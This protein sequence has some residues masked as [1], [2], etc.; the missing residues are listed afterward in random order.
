MQHRAELRNWLIAL[1]ATAILVALCVAFVDR[2]AAI[3]FDRVLRHTP[4]L[5]WI[6]RALAPLDLTIAITL[7][8]LIASGIWTGPGRS[9]PAWMRVPWLVSW[10]AVWATLATIVL[11][12]VFGRASPDPVYVQAGLYG[13]RPL[14]NI[15]YWHSFPSGTAAISTAIA[16]ALWILLPR[17]R[18]PGVLLAALLSVAVVVVNYHWV[19]D[20][21]TGIFLGAFIG[22]IT[23][24]YASRFDGQ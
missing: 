15:P 14:H 5:A 18:S 21:I 16:T 1:A 3:F 17:W 20:V 13:F 22:W 24:R 2:P 19:S 9:H 11:K 7:L 23:V 10:A 4:A 12:R 8:F 6:A